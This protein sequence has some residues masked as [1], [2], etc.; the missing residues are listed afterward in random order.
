MD[1]L[2]CVSPSNRVLIRIHTPRLNATASAKASALEKASSYIK[3]LG[4]MSLSEF[5]Q[6]SQYFLDDAVRVD[7]IRLSCRHSDLVGHRLSREGR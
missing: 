2:T 1:D 7:G 5:A 3:T 4:Q 6:A